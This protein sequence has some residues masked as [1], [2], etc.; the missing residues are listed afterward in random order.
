M[1]PASQRRSV[2]WRSRIKDLVLVALAFAL[3][4]LALGAFTAFRIWDV[5]NHDGRRP[6]DAIVVMGAAQYNGRPS[7]VLAARLDHAIELYQAGYGRYLFLT[8]GNLPGDL[9][10]EAETGRRYALRRGVPA[11]AILIENRGGSTLESIRNVRAVLDEKGLRTAL[12]VSDR[13]HML[14]V[15]RLA[16]D[17]GIEA[18]GSPTETSPAD[19]QQP[20]HF[21]AFV[22]EMGALG[23][24][25]FLSLDAP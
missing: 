22:H 24:Y 23:Y 12:F 4:G 17:S 10:T 9:T 20:M 25:A 16:A 1:R 8:G 14:R 11:S 2:T 15:L 21:N 7:A 5:G 13:T 3:G 19:S 18:W 6:V